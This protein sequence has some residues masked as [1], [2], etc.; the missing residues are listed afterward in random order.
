MCEKQITLFIFLIIKI[1]VI[2]IVP[3][4]ILL[5]KDK[6]DKKYVNRAYIIS[7]ALILLFIVLR[8]TNNVCVTNSNVQGLIIN[9]YKNTKGILKEPIDFSNIKFVEPTETIDVGTNEIIYYYNNNKSPLSKKIISCGNKEVYM[10]NVGNNITA[11]SMLLSAKLK[12]KID[13]ISIL[14]LCLENEI[15]DCDKGVDTNELLNLI[16]RK[17]N[18]SVRSIDNQE[19]TVRINTGDIVMA[20]T[21]FNMY[22]NNVDCGISNIILYKI[23]NEG[24]FNILNPND[25]DYDYI[26]PEN[27][28]GYGAVIKAKTNSLDWHSSDISS[29]VSRYIVIE[30]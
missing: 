23:N 4:V 17:Y 7:V 22:S 12:Q 30:K 9:N 21:R 28:T 15:F 16:S 5:F 27:T 18:V 8:I 2:I 29:I 3:L 13:P 25:R 24:K 19:A 6:V 14:D 10:K 11:V 26:C 20:E 1:F